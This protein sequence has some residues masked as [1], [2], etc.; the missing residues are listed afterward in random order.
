MLTTELRAR[1]TD[2]DLRLSDLEGRRRRAPVLDAINGDAAAR[3]RID[4][5]DA[6]I[7]QAKRQCSE[8]ALAIEQS[9]ELEAAEREA[10][11]AREADQRLDQAR[12]IGAEI[13]ETARGFDKAIAEAV[14]ALRRRAVL[15]TALQKTGCLESQYAN[16]IATRP[17]VNQAL[18]A[19]GMGAFA[20][21]E[22]T[23]GHKFR[24]LV[25]S[26]RGALTGIRRPPVAIKQA[27]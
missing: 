23:A 6:E 19:A 24:P 14:A 22:H 8:L 4:R 21:I 5:L 2:A 26:D 3:K 18:I 10:A 16:R 12:Q 27:A 17:P 1:L 25:D 15:R 7:E 9:A 13:V 11:A 20:E